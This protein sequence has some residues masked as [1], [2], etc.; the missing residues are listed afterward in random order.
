MANPV[1]RIHIVLILTV[2]ASLQMSLNIETE[3]NARHFAD[4]IFRFF[5]RNEE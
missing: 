2:H 5:L 1:D 4:Y 3:T